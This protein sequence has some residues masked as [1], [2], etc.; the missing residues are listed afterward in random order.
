MIEGTSTAGGKQVRYNCPFCLSNVGKPDTKMHLYFDPHRSFGGV[1][2]QFVCFR[3]G[4]RGDYK[5][6]QHYLNM[7]PIH[8]SPIDRRL[9]NFKWDVDEEDTVA[10]MHTVDPS[11]KPIERGSTEECYMLHRG[12][13]RTHI[14]MYNLQAGTESLY[15]RVV[16][17]SY[18]EGDL[19]FWQARGIFSYIHPK[20]IS[21]PASSKGGTV[22]NLE[23]ASGFKK[24]YVKE[25]P[26]NAIMGGLDCV[27]LFGKEASPAQIE[28]IINTNVEH[29]VICLDTDAFQWSLKLAKAFKNKEPNLSVS[30]FIPLY[31]KDTVDT[32]F[33]TFRS[34]VK[35]RTFTFDD[36]CSEEKLRLKFDEIGRDLL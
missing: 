11:C 22:F 25:G 19:T 5:K 23:K 1:K 10:E 36:V 34:L 26:L 24:I 33:K 16:I 13:T 27:A 18:H 20:Y 9:F 30:V 31:M 14:D 6:L 2:G 4:E 3:C 8:R 12:F 32:G 28:A 17:P 29:V 15:D 21:P 35:T 7:G